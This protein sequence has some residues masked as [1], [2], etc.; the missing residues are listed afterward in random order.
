MIG[1][2][3]RRMAIW[4]SLR[5]VATDLHQGTKT[6]APGVVYNDRFHRFANGSHWPR[7]MA[8]ADLD[9]DGDLDP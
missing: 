5:L 9:T 3:G 6:T 1:D 4:T 2:D 8:L 7:P